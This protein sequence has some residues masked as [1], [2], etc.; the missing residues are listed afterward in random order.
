ME[1]PYHVFI[2]IKVHPCFSANAAVHLGKKGRRNLYKGDS[3]Q[4]GRGSKPTQ[5]SG[6]TSS[7]SYQHIAAVKLFLN[8]EFI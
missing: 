3:P 8:Q 2:R 6:N 1:S 5:I 7:K 4:I